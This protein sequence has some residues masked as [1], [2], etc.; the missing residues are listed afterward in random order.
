MLELLDRSDLSAAVA[1]RCCAVFTRLAEAEAAVHGKPLNEVHFHEVS[2]ID[3][4]I[5]VIGVSLLLERL[6]VRTV[7]CSPVTVGSGFV[8]CAHGRLPVPAPATAELLRGIPVRQED[9]GV[10]MTTPTGAALAAALAGTFGPAPEMRVE[11]I[12]YG[13]GTRDLPGRSNV[14]RLFL[15]TA[16]EARA[17]RDRVCELVCLIDDMS[18][19]EVARAADRLRECGALDVYTIA[20]AGKMGRPAVEMTVLCPLPDVETMA[21]WVLAETSSFGVRRREVERS[22][23]P[24]EWI[25]VQVG[26]A[27]VRVKVGCLGGGAYRFAAEYEDAAAVADACGCSLRQIMAQAEMQAREEFM[28]RERGSPQ[29]TGKE[30]S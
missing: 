14:V 21:A 12:G 24:R 7:S 13:A 6:A 4:I 25:G 5:D 8:D 30:R 10:E 20:A 26:N 28:Q 11:R 9:T 15:G 27:P 1:E 2:G 23:L 3:T 17:G 29:E 16:A 18:G 22:I 19:E